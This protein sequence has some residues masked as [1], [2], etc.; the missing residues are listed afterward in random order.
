MARFLGKIITFGGKSASRLD[1]S[2]IVAVVTGWDI[3][4]EASVFIN[5]DGEDE[6]VVRLTGG[7]NNPNQSHVVFQEG[8]SKEQKLVTTETEFRFRVPK[9]KIILDTEA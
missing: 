1:Q 5:Q 3:G 2:K 6:V 4:V 7:S 8:K 9:T